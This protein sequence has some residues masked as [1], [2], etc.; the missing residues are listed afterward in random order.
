[1]SEPSGAEDRGT[2]CP[3]RFL[4]SHSPACPV[5]Q[6]Q[7]G[8]VDTA[9]APPR[10]QPGGG[11]CAAASHELQGE[12]QI[13]AG[14]P[15][16]VAPRMTPGAQAPGGESGLM[17][18][19]H[20]AA[21]TDTLAVPDMGRPAGG[22]SLTLAERAPIEAIFGG[23]MAL[24]WLSRHGS[25]LT[26][27]PYGL[28]KAQIL[29][30]AGN[31]GGVLALEKVRT[32]HAGL[33]QQGYSNEQIVTL[34]GNAGGALALGKVRTLHAGLT[35]LG[36]S[37]FQIV[38][39]AGNVGGAAA[40][41]KLWTLHATLRLLGYTHAEIVRIAVRPGSARTLEQLS[42]MHDALVALGYTR[43]G[44]LKIASGG[45]L[46]LEKVWVLHAGLIALGYTRAEIVKVAAE[47]GASALGQVKQ[48]HADLGAQGYNRDEIAQL[49]VLRED[50]LRTAY[51]LSG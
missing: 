14:Q 2:P 49:A 43:S 47:G 33:G 9:L 29:R 6:Q 12:A 30:I 5:C 13:P 8:E 48:V 32:L 11:E 36:Y 18:L 4:P 39:V 19:A 7:W 1:M 26:Q 27:A 40:L 20:A 45:A 22:L 46:A 10:L 44:V 35:T 17:A 3:S 42:T 16:N 31:D 38:A 24:N 41:E 34:A 50:A 28:T 15:R 21:S 37:R 23:R 25:L 51:V